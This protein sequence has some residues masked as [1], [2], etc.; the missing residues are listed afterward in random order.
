MKKFLSFIIA[1]FMVFIMVGCDLAG[2]DIGGI[3]LPINN[4]VDLDDVFINVSSSIANKDNVTENIELPNKFSHVTITWSSE[5]EAVISSSGVVVR[6]DEDTRVVLK[7]DLYY[8]GEHKQYEVI[9]TVKAKEKELPPVTEVLSIKDVKTKELGGTY[10]IQGTV[11]ASFKTGVIV[12]D[13]SDMIFCYL[14]NEKAA[15]LNVGDQIELEG[16]TSLYGGAIQFTDASTFEKKATGSVNQVFPNLMTSAEFLALVDQ[17]GEIKPVRFEGVLSKSGNYYNV[18]IE[19]AEG[20]VQGSLCSPKDD[21]SAFVGKKVEVTGYFAYVTVS[22]AGATYIYVA[23]NEVKLS[24]G[25]DVPPTPTYSTFSDVKAGTTGAIYTVKDVTVVAVGSTGF[26]GKDSTGYMFVYVGN[27]FANDV[28]IGDVVEVSGTSSIYGNAYQLGSATYTKSSSTTVVQPN[29]RT[30]DGASFDALNAETINIEYVTVEGICRVNGSYRNLEVEGASIVG[31]LLIPASMDVSALAGKK[32]VVTGYFVYVNGSSTKYINIIPIEMTEASSQP[33]VEETPVSTIATVLASATGK[34]YRVQG[35]V[36]ATTNQSVLIKDDTGYIYCYY[37]VDYAKD[38]VVGDVIDVEGVTSSYGGLVQFNRSSYKKIGTKE[39][40]TPNPLV[41]DKDAYDAMAASTAL[42]VQYVQIEGKIVISGN[43]VNFEVEGSNTVGSFT[44]PIEDYSNLNGKKATITGYFIGITSSSKYFSVVVTK[45][46]ESEGGDVPPTPTPTVITIAEAKALELNSE[47]TVKGTVIALSKE[48]F[49]IQDKTDMILVYVGSS[50]ANDLGLAYG[51]EVS[52]KIAKYSNALQISNPTYTIC[53]ST[54]K[55]E[56]PNPRVLDGTALDALNNGETPV[57]EYVQIQGKLSISGKYHNVAVDGA[58][59]VGSLI[60]PVQDMTDLNGKTIKATGFYLYIS[61]SSTKYANILVTNVEEVL[62]GDVPP[63]PT[64]TVITISEAKALELNSECLVQG[65]VIALSKESFLIQDKT[66]KILVY[67]GSGMAQDLVVGNVVN[68]SGKISKYSNALQISNPTYTIG[69]STENVEYPN[70]RVLDGTA[71]DALNNGEAPVIEYVQIQGKLSIS[72]KYHNVAVEGATLVGSLVSPAT[73]LSELNGKTIKVTGY[74]LY[75]NG[76][77]TKYANILVTSVEEV[78][79]GDVPP[80]PTPTV[81]TIAEAKA[82]ELNS[83]CL[84]QGTVIALSKESFLIQDKTDK[85]LVYV[86]SGMAQDLVVGNVVNVSGKISKYSNALQISNPTYTI[87]ESTENVE[88]PN[89]RV[90][91]GTAL[92]ALNNGEAPV[93]EYV[94]IQGKLSISGKYHNVAV[95]GATLVG[96][97]VSPATDLSE[98]NG[99]TIKVTGYYLYI[100]GSS[101]KYANILVTSVEEVEGGDTPVEPEVEAI[102]KIKAGEEGV[103]VAIEGVVVAI[104][105]EGFLVKDDTGLMLAYVG[106]GFGLDVRPGTLVKV[107]GTTAFYGGVM[108]LSTPTYTVKGFDDSFAQPEARVLDLAAYE[109]L[110]VPYPTPE[111]VKLQA[112]LTISGKYYNLTVG[113]SI[114]TGSIVAPIQ[115][116]SLYNDKLIDI[117]GY[118]VYVSGSSKKYISFI[119]TDVSEAEVDPLA[120]IKAIILNMNNRE[121]LIDQVLPT[122]YNGYTITWTSSNGDVLSGEGIVTI[123]EADT[124]VTLVATIS[125]GESS[126]TVSIVMVVKGYTKVSA[127]LGKTQEELADQFYAFK[128]TVV[129]TARNGFTILDDNYIYVFIKNFNNALNVGDVVCVVGAVSIYNNIKEVVPVNY[130]V[131]GTS[132]V[133]EPTYTALT[134]EQMAS[135][136]QNP[137]TTAVELRA[138]IKLSGNYTNLE[139]QGSEIVGSILANDALDLAYA[140]GRGVTVKGYFLYTSTSNGVTY[141]NIMVTSVEVDKLD[142]NVAI[143]QLKEEFASISGVKLVNDISFETEYEGIAMSFVSSNPNV[144]TNSGVVTIPEQD[145]EVT[146]TVTMTNGTI[147]DTTTFTVIVKTY[148]SIASLYTKTQ[149]ELNAERYIVKGTVVATTDISF[150]IKQDDAY[151]YVYYG[152]TYAKDL[153]IGDNVIVRGYLGYYNGTLEFNNNIGY[154]KNGEPTTVTVEYPVADTAFFNNLVDNIHITP[155]ET[156]GLIRINNQYVDVDLY[157]TGFAGSLLKNNIDLSGFADK[158]VKIKGYFVYVAGGY[159]SIIP[160]SVEEIQAVY[161][162]ITLVYNSDQGAVEYNVE[163]LEYIIDGDTVEFIVRE[164]TPLYVFDYALVGEQRIET[165]KFTITDI[166]EDLVV[167]VVFKENLETVAYEITYGQHENKSIYIVG[168]GDGMRLLPATLV[169]GKYTATF[170][171]P[172]KFYQVREYNVAEDG[173]TPDAATPYISSSEDLSKDDTTCVLH[174]VNEFVVSSYTSAVNNDGSWTISAVFTFSN[175]IKNLSA[176]VLDVRALGY[177]NAVT[178]NENYLEETVLLNG[179][180]NLVT[181]LEGN[182]L[183]IS[184]TISKELVLKY[185]SQYYL[186]ASYKGRLAVAFYV[187]L[188]DGEKNI[189]YKNNLFQTLIYFN[190]ILDVVQ[191]TGKGT[192]DNPLTALDAYNIA[193]YLPEGVYTDEYFYIEGYVAQEVDHKYYNM[194]LTAGDNTFYVYGIRTSNN[195]YAY[196][197]N[198]NQVEEININVGDKVLIR[199]QVYHYYN[200][201]NGSTLETRG[202]QLIKIN[203]VAATYTVIQG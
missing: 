145:T 63:T 116:L 40:V 5:N 41:L 166:H 192:I 124:R 83:E 23:Y 16:P 189:S 114:V 50:F 199:A 33:P 156:Q 149:E 141:F 198:A 187:S 191:T 66:D 134:V 159:F 31:S 202:A 91:D 30:L 25:Q 68:V 2:G 74:Y 54:D 86:G 177:L 11:I 75:I 82:L 109:A 126:E 67:V 162:D 49:L 17:A 76:S 100:N 61:G 65:T 55:V 8:N 123:P 20:N 59:L 84:V 117:T 47:C 43:Y 197:T 174:S 35:T 15:G 127:V 10:K 175:E 130:K 98:L 186:T 90:L 201:N 102:S 115:D 157:L 46:E 173:S 104:S 158:Y 184:V 139:V 103:E 57:I 58:T 112:K 99:K 69:E 13:N 138:T 131:L 52:G 121:A 60:N 1:L 53:E 135:L 28:V 51:V 4:D 108:Q 87:G 147:T 125:N 183:T 137:V 142:P 179:K 153:I 136:A 196:G 185:T 9:V 148:T 89:P 161:H 3:D 180:T 119:I 71:L 152:N 48:S 97:L 176:E 118:F 93:I 95:E 178:N 169:D 188:F 150:L 38:L 146:F 77:S 26:L 164:T 45:V 44:Y 167:K 85:I 72:G 7:C 94:Q 132:E 62:G 70:P 92:D 160:T 81:I 19:G 170:P 171:F 200:K 29:P 12:I 14:G 165:N 168:Y 143:A 172:Q 163:H 21:L 181:S 193:A 107:K 106:S 18:A 133:T 195:E 56:Y 39:V 140:D 122:E 42:S 6:P 144:I 190:T 182:V 64:P 111:Y 203:D 105:A 113:D 79:G 80:T 88:Y 36:V 73:D 194:Y 154:A 22:A 37:S 27:S 128:G 110:N 32:V 120:E 155:I 96:S 129:A 78:E 151:V 24:D 34:N 101:T